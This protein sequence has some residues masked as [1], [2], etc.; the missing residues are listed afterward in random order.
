MRLRMHNKLC[1]VLAVAVITNKHMVFL[2][3]AH[4]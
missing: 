3:K 2:C 4:R 1:C